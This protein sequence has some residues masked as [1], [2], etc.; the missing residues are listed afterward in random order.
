MADHD[1]PM[2]ASIELIR[3][4]Q[5]G[6]AQALERLVRRYLPRLQRWASGRLPGYARGLAETQDIVQDALIGTVR[7]LP[8]FRDRGDGALQAYRNGM[9]TRFFH[10]RTAASVRRIITGRTALPR[11][12][13]SYTMGLY[14]YLPEAAATQL[15]TVMFDALRPGGTLLIANF[16][17]NIMDAGYMESMMDWHL[18]YRDDAEMRTLTSGIAIGDL[19]GIDQFHDPF[20]NITFLRVSK[21]AS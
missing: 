8:D 7:N 17:P 9:H 20:D 14:D 15:T 13:V 18:I 10:D 6:D 16:L 19:A 12:D 11:S 1:A 5:N 3:L 4:A 21:R 2:E